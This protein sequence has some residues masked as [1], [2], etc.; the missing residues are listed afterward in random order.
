MDSSSGSGNATAAIN[1]KL[2]SVYLAYALII[3]AITIIVEFLIAYDPS[4][5]TALSINLQDFHLYQL[6]TASFVHVNFDHFLGNVTAYLVIVIYGLILASILNRKRLYLVLTKVIV[7]AF[8]VFGALF[9]FFNLTTTYYAGLSGIDAALAGLVL[10]FWLLYLEEASG[11]DKGNYYGIALIVLLLLIIGIVGRYLMLYRTLADS[12]LVL[13]LA[14]LA[15]ML[16]LAIVF[17]W[18]QVADLYRLQKR[19]PA[20]SRLLTFSIIIALGYFIWNIFPARLANSTRV[21]SV[22][23]HVSGVILGI[24][25]GYFCMVYLGRIAWFRQEKEILLT[26]HS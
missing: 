13:W 14:G 8:L 21:V 5:R 26:L 15:A 19:L 4:F 16:V 18:N 2:F 22:S 17:L 6:F 3:P 1:L 10:L 23:L 9:T 25:V 20:S 7:G 11:R 12:V 24:L